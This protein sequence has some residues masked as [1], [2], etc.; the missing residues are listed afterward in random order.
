MKML[1]E[2]RVLMEKRG[3]TIGGKLGPDV[4]RAV[5]C[6]P[7]LSYRLEDHDTGKVYYGRADS[8]GNLTARPLTSTG[9]EKMGDMGDFYRDWNADKKARREKNLEKNKFQI[10]D[11]FIK[12]TDYHY[13]RYLLGDTLDY[14]PSTNKWRWRGKTMNGTV[15]HLTGFIRKQERRAKKN[16]AI[17]DHS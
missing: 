17:N 4:F 5:G 16:G 10:D 7:N 2:F 15:E 9:E 14:W 8:R 12:H 1:N 6:E 3:E 13:T 11:T